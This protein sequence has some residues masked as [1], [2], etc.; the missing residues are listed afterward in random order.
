MLT[1]IKSTY[2]PTDRASD[3]GIDIGSL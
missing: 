3:R 2:Q 1:N